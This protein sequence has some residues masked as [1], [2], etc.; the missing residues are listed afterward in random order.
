MKRTLIASAFGCA[1]ISALAQSSVTIYGVADAGAGRVENGDTHSTQLMS[2]VANGSRLGF[3]GIEDLGSGLNG[4]FVLEN[5]FNVDNGTVTQGGV[6]FGR[7][8]FVGLSSKSGWS[9]TA[10]RQNSPLANS[11]IA[12]DPLNWQYFGNTISTGLGVFESPGEGPASAGWQS[13]SRVNNSVVGKYTHG[14]FSAELM[15]GFG[16]EDSKGAGKLWSTG[17]TYASGPVMVTAAYGRSNQFAGSIVP[18]A[19]P[20][21]QD[22]YLVGGSYD[23]K[24]VKVS[25]GYYKFTPSTANRTPGVPNAF[26]PRADNYATY[27]IGARVPLPVGVLLVNA[28]KSTHEYATVADGEGVTFG[29]AYEYPLS[30]R[31]AL[32]ASY[33]QVVNN[34]TGLVSLTAAIPFIAPSKP[35]NNL[36]AYA[37]GI[38]HFF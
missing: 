7:Q 20:Q 2:G 13:N 5:G 10:G 37:V 33:G 25:S 8:S 18:G 15:Y 32:Y 19:D 14:P 38:R 12:A 9:L 17:V 27:W 11:M 24:V 22:Q 26:D 31:T 28:M 36:S 21:S 29:A 1:A 35:G 23:F 16:N 4:I 3:K 6:F 34:S 30:R